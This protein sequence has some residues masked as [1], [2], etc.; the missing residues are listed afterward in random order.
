MNAELFL[1]D[2][3]GK[4]AALAGLAA[5]LESRGNPFASLPRSVR[6]VVFLGMGSSRYAAA[7][8][9]LRLRS[10]GIDAVAEYASAAI[11]HPAGPDT[12]IVA[13]SAGGN[14]VETVDALSRHAGRSP[15]VVITNR[16]GSRAA[17]LADS[18][19]PMLAGEE[20]G[21]VACRTFQHTGLL[22]LALEARLTGRPTD[23][24]GMCR[25]VAAATADLLDRRPLWLPASAHLL[26]GPDGVYTIAP[27]ERSSS[28]EQAA[29]MLREGP[30]RRAD[31]CETGDWAHVDV[32]LT[33]SI[34]YRAVL[35][36]GSRYDDQAMGWLRSRGSVVVAVGADVPGAALSVRYR[37]DDDPMVA[38]L[39]E[40]LVVELVAATW[41][42]APA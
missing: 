22:L 21:G 14:S 15:I 24:A 2:L 39:T 11:G 33:R 18:V 38:L 1:T 36:A 12:L 17:G 20:A 23:V 32:Y 35:F 40:T 10:A 19:I 41:W 6:R 7:V 16:T 4:T 34:D 3:E 42:R 25:R 31:A 30:R 9:A 8:A 5:A 37:G 27:V 28:A 29:L 13:I 26:D